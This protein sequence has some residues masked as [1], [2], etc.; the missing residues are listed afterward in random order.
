MKHYLC[1]DIGGT[2]IKSGVFNENGNTVVKHPLTKTNNTVESINII[3][4][5]RGI[6]ERSINTF[7]IVGVCISTAGV[8]DPIKGSVVYA[9]YTIPDY[10][11]THLKEIVENE[12]HL[13]C[14][15]ENDVNAACLG[16]YW[17]GQLQAVSTG[18]CLTVGTGIGGAVLINGEIQHGVGFTAGEV[19]YLN[20]NGSNFQDI[21]STTYLVN[22][23]SERMGKKINGKEIFELASMGNE[24]CVEEIDKMMTNLSIGLI[25]IMYLLNPEVIV[26][27]G[28][29]MSQEAYLSP[30][31]EEKIK[32]MIEAE[33]FNKTQIKFATLKN[34]AGMIGALYNFKKRHK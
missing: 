15:V 19:G 32:S 11:N 21:A 26:L 1:I 18:V 34:D 5:I 9:G 14:E 28:G 23:V 24:I 7:E 29:I 27:G 12:Y 33:R 2:T 13:P 31:I 3:N 25:N 20:I 17:K 30:I 4:S 6:I 22:Q 8:V 10:S 16:E